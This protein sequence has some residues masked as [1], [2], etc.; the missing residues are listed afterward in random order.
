[1]SGFLDKVRSTLI[2]EYNTRFGKKHTLRFRF[3]DEDGE[4]IAGIGHHAEKEKIRFQNAINELSCSEFESLSAYILK[5]AGCETFWKTP[6][7][8]DQ[9][10]DAFGY[11]NFLE[12]RDGEWF[13]GIPRLIFLAQAKHFSDCKV[14]SKDIREFVGSF[15]LAAHKIYSTVDEKYTDLTIPPLAPVALL[16]I[17]TEEVPL[18]VKRMAVKAGIVVLSSDDLY[19]VLIRSWSDRPVRLTQNWFIK[20]LRKSIQNIPKAN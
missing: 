8:H 3:L 10:L 18:T 12:R 11:R 1:M 20:K 7:S 16:F 14:G 9:G 2:D 6:D 15:K 19:D 4:K 17:T 5:L 13:A